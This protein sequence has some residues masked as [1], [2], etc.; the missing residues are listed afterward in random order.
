MSYGPNFSDLFYRSGNKILKN[1]ETGDR[2]PPAIG[3]SCMIPVPFTTTSIV[4]NVSIV[5][6][7]ETVYI[8]RPRHSSLHRDRARPGRRDL[9]DAALPA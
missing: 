5:F 6:L 8:R 4:P 9:S 3:R 7:K 1:A 2:S